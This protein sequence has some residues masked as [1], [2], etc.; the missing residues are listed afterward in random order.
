MSQITLL[1]CRPKF[2]IQSGTEATCLISAPGDN[3]ETAF[4]DRAAMPKT[5]RIKG[6]TNR[7]LPRTVG[8]SARPSPTTSEVGSERCAFFS[9][10]YLKRQNHQRCRVVFYAEN[11]NATEM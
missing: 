11:Y 1:C 2:P 4:P 7:N 3:I 5:Q 10:Q 9:V 8:S 6:E